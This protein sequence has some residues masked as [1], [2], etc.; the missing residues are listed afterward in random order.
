MIWVNGKEIVQDHF[1]AGELKIKLQPTTRD[2]VDIAWHYENDAELFTVACIRQF[3]A[4][5]RCI[6]YL[7]YVPH[8]RMDRVKNPEDVFTLKT[9]AHFINSLDF[10]Q[11]VTWDVHSNVSLALIDRVRNE[12]PMVWIIEAIQ[13]LGYAKNSICLFFP[14]E[15]AQKRYGEM[16]PDFKQAFGIKKRNWETGKIEGYMIVGEE[17]VKDRYVLIIDDICS[18]GNTFVKAAEA[19]REAGAVDISL[20]ITH[21]EDAINK[22]DI[23]KNNIFENVFTT[24]SLIRT[25]ETDSKLTVIH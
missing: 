25:P 7:P 14:D 16:F 18:Y 9:F 20:F 21:C 24:N 22:G 17:N 11:V 8:A 4:K 19:I 5:T 15:G 10:D 1:S 3:Y 2:R 23:F 12:N 13:E 6:L